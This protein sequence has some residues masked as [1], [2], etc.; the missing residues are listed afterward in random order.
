VGAPARV[1]AVAPEALLSRKLTRK[2]SQVLGD[3]VSVARHKF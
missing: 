1:A 2:L 3:V